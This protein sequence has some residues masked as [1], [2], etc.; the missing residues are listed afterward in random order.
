MEEF[1][2]PEEELDGFPTIRG[3]SKGKRLMFRLP[4]GVQLPYIKLNW[5]KQD[6]PKK[7]FT[8]F[9]FR[10]AE[11]E[12]KARQDLLPPSIH[13]DTQ[14]PYRWEVQP[15]TP[16]P[17]PPAWLVSIVEAW[18][19]FKPQLQGV[20]PWHVAPPKPERKTPPPRNT[21][22]T[23]AQQVIDAYLGANPLDVALDAYGYKRIGKRYLSPHS[24][25]NLAG[26]IPFPD[27]A[28]CWIHHASDPLCSE[29][30][31]QRRYRSTQARTG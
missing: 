31:G 23:T 13:P 29:E 5:P 24:G 19:Q 6:E 21:D 14:E 25:T 12:G 3:A 2:I 11:P 26:V 9:E 15:V 18:E 22:N 17:E 4:E 8:V 10:A 1:G 27:G 30:S 20:C 16:W 7:H 28:A